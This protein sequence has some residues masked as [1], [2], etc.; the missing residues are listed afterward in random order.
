M[1]S[2]QLPPSLRVVQV[3]AVYASALRA[4]R[5]EYMMYN[6]AA[7]ALAA[8]LPR[9]SAQLQVRASFPPSSPK[10]GACL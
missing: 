6:L 4:Y 1:A 2:D 8:V 7:A 5:E 10:R 9:M 3:E